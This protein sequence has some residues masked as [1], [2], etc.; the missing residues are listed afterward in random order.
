MQLIV[1]ILNNQADLKITELDKS[2]YSE[3]KQNSVVMTQTLNKFLNL[4]QLRED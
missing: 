1:D 2:N 4:A 3:Y